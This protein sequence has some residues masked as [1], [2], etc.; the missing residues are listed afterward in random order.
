MLGNITSFT[1]KGLR[2]WFVQRVSAILIGAYVLFLL[3][4]LLVHPQLDY[5]QWN[6]LFHSD[7]MRLLSFLVLLSLLAHAWI[8]I[9]TISTDYI[10]LSSVR[11]VF[12]VVVILALLACV[13]WGVLILW[14]I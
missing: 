8:G 3:A 14:S 12:Q 10:K 9:W 13:V 11:I 2:D 6:A 7:I 5:L 4:Y 1:G